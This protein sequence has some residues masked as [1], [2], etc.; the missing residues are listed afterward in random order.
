MTFRRAGGCH[1][2]ESFSGKIEANL[3]QHKSSNV[4]FFLHRKKSAIM[5]VES[6]LFT[7][8]L[9]STIILSDCC[10]QFMIALSE[11]YVP[12]LTTFVWWSQDSG[13][14]DGHHCPLT[15][16]KFLLSSLPN[17]STCFTFPLALT[18]MAVIYNLYDFHQAVRNFHRSPSRHSIRRGLSLLAKL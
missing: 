12:D 7:I 4:L 13:R 16:V 1:R 10:S 9:L 8:I 18:S 2:L 11:G 14:R 6:R 15:D 17:Y 3:Q 5:S